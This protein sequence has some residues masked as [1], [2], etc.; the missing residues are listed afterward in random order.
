MGCISTNAQCDYPES[1]SAEEK[2]FWLVVELPP[3]GDYYYYDIGYGTGEN[4]EDAIDKAISNI[5][6]KQNLATGQTIILDSLTTLITPLT[7]KARIEHQYW[8]CCFD[9]VK[10]KD[11]YYMNILCIVANNPSYDI[12]KVQTDKKYFKTYR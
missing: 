10:H 1:K 7:V 12:S 11:V 9:P 5:C 6:K 2:P 4:Y 3:N 8:E